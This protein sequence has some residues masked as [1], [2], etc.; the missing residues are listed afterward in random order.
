GSRFVDGYF[1][2]KGGWV[3]SGA[4]VAR[5]AEDLRRNGVVVRAAT[6]FESLL[7][8]GGR[9]TGVLTRGGERIEADVVVLAS[10]AWVP[11]MAPWIA[12]AFRTVGQPVFQ[13]APD[14]SLDRTLFEASRFPVFG[15]DIARTGW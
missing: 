2:A 1:N 13:L 7:E 4:V 15:A 11:T 12:S 10:G 8:R 14:V 3:E 9:A 5:L 6:W